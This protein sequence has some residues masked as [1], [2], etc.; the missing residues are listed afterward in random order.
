[1]NNQSVKYIEYIMKSKI[2]RM[3]LPFLILII[4]LI[5]LLKLWFDGQKTYSIFDLNKDGVCLIPNVLSQKEIKKLKKMKELEIK[6]YIIHKFSKSL[7]EGYTFQDYV[8]VIK[9]SSVHTCHRDNN[10]D[11]F[12]PGQKYQSYTILFYLDDI[13]K[14]L[15]VIPKSHLSPTNHAINLTNDLINIECN[16]G[17]A[18]IFNA[19]LIH[20]G[21]INPDNM[22]IQMKITHKDDLEILNYYQNFNKVLNKENNI[23][24]PILRMQRNLTCMFPYMSN[25]TQND[26]IKSARGTDNGAEITWGQKIFSIVFYGNKDFYDLPNVNM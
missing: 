24:T 3:I 15:G 18:I 22:R 10:G 8:W 26:N 19:N 7:P 20:V 17:D 21:T 23:S 2:N 6:K 11:F 9:K 16:K 25:L 14:C 1:M 4:I 5:F 13:D 12:N